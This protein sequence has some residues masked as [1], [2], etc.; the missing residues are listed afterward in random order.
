MKNYAFYVFI[1]IFIGWVTA[2]CTPTL[3]GSP[4]NSGLILVEGEIIALTTHSIHIAIFQIRNPVERTWEPISPNKGKQFGKYI[5]FDNLK[6]GDYRLRRVRSHVREGGWGTVSIN[7]RR[8]TKYINAGQP[9]YIGKIIM[10][11]KDMNTPR[12]NKDKLFYD[13]RNEIAA[14]EYFL[15]EYKDSPWT[16][17]VQERLRKIR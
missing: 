11:M 2:G 1:A 5:L 14:W 16:V 15:K 4:E 17:P 12:E 8:I 10:N 13:D 3:I 9:V 7:F 6:P